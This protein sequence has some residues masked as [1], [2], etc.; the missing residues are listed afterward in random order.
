MA[1]ILTG[2]RPRVK[3][4]ALDLDK[5]ITWYEGITSN[6][7]LTAES[8]ATQDETQREPIVYFT[9]EPQPSH[10]LHALEGK[11]T[12]V[13]IPEEVPGE[14]DVDFFVAVGL[15]K[16][17]PSEMLVPSREAEVA[18]IASHAEELSD[19]RGQ[20]LVVEGQRL[21]AHS[22]DFLEVVRDARSHGIE[23]PYVTKLPAEEERPFIG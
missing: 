8:P 9:G 11:L 7:P 5:G 10:P 16:E 23:I 20:W 18:W 3:T 2:V 13:T 6:R 21:I 1:P 22:F 12:D 15:P 17:M 4:N 19:F 14:E